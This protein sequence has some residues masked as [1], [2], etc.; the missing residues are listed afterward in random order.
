MKKKLSALK[1]VVLSDKN[2]KLMKQEALKILSLL[3]NMENY[4]NQQRGII[5]EE[6][7]C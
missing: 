1:R 2:H 7:F 5:M 3:D 4:L 6:D